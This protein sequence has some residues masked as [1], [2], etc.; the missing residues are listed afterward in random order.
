MTDSIFDNVHTVNAWADSEPE[1]LRI[2]ID[3]KA[4]V[5]VGEYSR[6]GRSRGRKPV[7]ALDHEMMPKQ[8]LVPGGIVEPAEGRAFVFFTE[9]NKTSEFVVDGL[10]L[11]WAFRKQDL[12]HVRRLVINMDNGPE[13][14]SHRR[15]F[16]QML[17]QFADQERLEIR[18]VYYPP[19][20]SKYN[21]IERYWG[22]LERSWNGYLLDSVQAV[23]QR[24]GNFVWR[25]H[26]TVVSLIDKVYDK[27]IT[28]RTTEKKT[29]EK[30]LVRSD[31][32]PWWDVTIKPK[33]VF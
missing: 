18:L 21:N 1:T 11:W 28:L 10:R 3:T 2:S 13:C 6:G 14:S 9:S 22:G 30:R 7:A 15:Y 17:A 27:G 31:A 29:L 20:H 26:R 4:T 23:L 19:Y 32:L 12:R 24:A 16:L 33:M 5:H 25:T 8:K